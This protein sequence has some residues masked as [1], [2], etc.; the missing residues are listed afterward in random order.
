MKIVHL[1]KTPCAGAI[2]ALSSAIRD[3]TCHESRVI[4]NGGKVNNLS[5]PYDTTFASSELFPLLAR[6]DVIVLHQSID[7]HTTP[8]HDFLLGDKNKKVC[9]FFHSHPSICNRRAEQTGFPVF[10]VAQYQSL[11]FPGSSPVRNVIRFDRADWPG[12]QERD[13]DKFWIGYSPT[14]RQSQKDTEPGSSEWY[15][16]KGFDVTEPILDRLDKKYEHVE[17]V[18]Y[19]GMDY[20]RCIQG[21]A[22]CDVLL[23][24]V[25]TGSYHRTT[26][27]GLALGIPTVVNVSSPVHGV[28]VRAAGANDFPVVH[29]D[30]DTLEERLEWLVEMDPI[31][32]RRMGNDS[33]DWMVRHWHPRDI[34]REFCEQLAQLPTFAEVMPT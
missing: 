6:A 12:R 15:H 2:E 34:A 8:V 27:E 20:D 14:F 26:L 9:C 29:A 5:F 17:V 23:D 19:E 13:D 24:E 21:K 4:S 31:K 30:I 22:L 3:Y 7:H 25:V 16:S 18:L 1:S 28:V 11:L 10:T 33:H 32:R